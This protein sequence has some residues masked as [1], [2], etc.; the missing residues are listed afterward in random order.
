LRESLRTALAGVAPVAEEFRSRPG[1]VPNVTI[2]REMTV[3]LGHR[4]V[5]LLFLGRGNTAGDLV[6]WL[7]QERILATGDLVDS[8][9]PYIG[10]GYPSDQ[11]KALER[12][13][14]LGAETIIPGHGDTL[15]GE[16]GLAHV[17]HLRDFLCEVTSAVS[18]VVHEIGNNPRDYEKARAEVEK[19]VNFDAWRQKF[20]GDDKE[21][22]EFFDGF[23]RPGIVQ[24][25]FAE[26]WPR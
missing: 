15:R 11:V 24:A 26:I 6:V 2:D 3:D 4:E 5:H 23:P 25:A 7:P 18:A 17:R 14:A 8:P 22:Q 10:S 1:A 13:I 9:V 19:R 12:L 16:S 20:A 21:D